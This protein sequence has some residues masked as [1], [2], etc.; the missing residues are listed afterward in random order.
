MFK[1][2]KRNIYEV[3]NQI[4]S[5]NILKLIKKFFSV[6]EQP[7][8][9]MMNEFFSIGNYPKIIKV[10]KK[11]KIKLY[12]IDDFSTFNLIFCREDYFKPKNIKVVIDIG[13]NIGISTLY[14]LVDNPTCKIYS[15][16]PSSKNFLRQKSNMKIFKKNVIIKKIGISNK[17]EIIKLYLSK[18]GV[19]NSKNKIINAKYEIVKLV[20]I[21]NILEEIILK[22]NIVD[23]IKI[24]V[25]GM[26]TD[27]LKV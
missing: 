4:F 14:W 21:N 23:V 18:S 24:D 12:S 6:H 17:N 5:L 20:N 15:F 25:E 3:L 22:F 16:E 1:I 19:N 8:S 11:Y 9:A 7:I 27:I 26:E 10:M 13:S 2:G